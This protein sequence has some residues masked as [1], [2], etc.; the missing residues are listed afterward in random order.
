MTVVTH[1]LLIGH[2]TKKGLAANLT[3]STIL[4]YTYLN[5]RK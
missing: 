4:S 1:P 3:L 2:V 5:T